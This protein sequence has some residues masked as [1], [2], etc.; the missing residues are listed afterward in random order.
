MTGTEV[1]WSTPDDPEIWGFECPTCKA[2][3]GVW[4]TPDLADLKL[5]LCVCGNELY[6]ICDNRIMCAK[7]GEQKHWMWD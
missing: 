1:K 7:C 2:M 6:V 4:L 5:D 3:N